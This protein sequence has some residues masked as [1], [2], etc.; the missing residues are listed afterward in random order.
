MANNAPVNPQTII[1][2]ADNN[3]NTDSFFNSNNA[4][5]LRQNGIDI[6]IVYG[7]D[8]IHTKT[9][10]S[11]N[12]RSLGQQLDANGNPIYEMYE[13]IGKDLLEE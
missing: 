1:P 11:V 7:A 6:A 13:F 3:N 4:D 5:A 8:Q 9:I 2:M 12:F 10:K